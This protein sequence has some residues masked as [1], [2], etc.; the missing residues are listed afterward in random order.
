[1]V[2]LLRGL[3]AGYDVHVAVLDP[4]GPLSTDLEH[5]GYRPAVFPL[6]GSLAHPNTAFQVARLTRWLRVNRIELVH[7]HD[8]YAT[9]L[10]VPAARL[11]LA[12]VVVGRLDLAHWHS[13]AQRTAL[14][15]MTRLADH[16]VVNAEAI[17]NM[18]I[19]QEGIAPSAIT[20][21]R[22][23]IDV[24][25]F[26]LQTEKGLSAPIPDEDQP[27]AVLVANMNHPVKRQEDFLRALQMIA[28]AGSPLRGWLVGDGP[29]RPQLEKLAD[30]LGLNGR[31]HFLG[32][33]TDIAAIYARASMG[34]LCSSAEGLSNAIIEGMA[35]RLPMVV[36]DAGGN[37]E[38][39]SH[40][41]RGLLVPPERPSD[42][43]SAMLWM[44]RNR[45]AARQMGEAARA[46]VERK[47]SAER[48]ASSHDL[49]Y[50]SL[51]RSGHRDLAL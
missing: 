46:Y 40:G 48:L 45:I 29:R 22:N 49:L 23:G 27:A 24:R 38:L 51:V 20:L 9:I 6:N 28:S 19:E 17:R 3:P 25:L 11:A 5:L 37:S 35:A 36:T 15:A 16:V 44:Q 42:L 14:R 43:A 21:I 33:R 26:D 10:A 4:R 2:Q 7:V 1:M 47:L 31:A 30:A 50:R 12:K 8:F 39:I 41:T 32:H 13:E 34:V 18:L